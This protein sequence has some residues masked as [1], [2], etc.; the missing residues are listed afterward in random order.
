VQHVID[1][2]PAGFYGSFYAGDYADEQI[3]SSS[4]IKL[5]STNPPIGGILA[6]ETFGITASS[7]GGVFQILDVENQQ[8][9]EWSSR[10][11]DTVQT[12][13]SAS[14]YPNA[15]QINPSTGGADVAGE[16]GS[17]IGFYIGMPVKFV[18]AIPVG[19]PIVSSSPSVDNKYYV[20]SLVQLPSTTSVGATTLEVGYKY[21]ITTLGTTDFTLVGASSNTVGLEFT[22]TGVGTGTGTAAI[23]EATGFTISIMMD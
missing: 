17:T 5:Y 4:S 9:L 19:S 16:I 1:W 3:F 8:T 10:T 22:A 11:R 14:L 13:G 7:Q 23:M 20:K 15:I 2:E 18:G 12:Y 6:G 21:S